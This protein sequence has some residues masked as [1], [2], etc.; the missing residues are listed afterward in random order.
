GEM[1]AT[2]TNASKGT[3][4]HEY[5]DLYNI[6][7]I[8]FPDKTNIQITYNQDKDWVTSFK[9]RA[10]C[11]E[12]YEYKDDEEDAVNNYSSNVI[13]VCNKKVTN[14]SSYSFWHKTRKD[15]ARYLARSLTNINGHEEDIYYHEVYGRPS[16]TIKDGRIQTFEYFADGQ[17]KTRTDDI[18][19]YSYKYD[20]SCHKVS[21]LVQKVK[22]FSVAENFDK[23][24]RNPS[25]TDNEKPKQQIKTFLTDFTYDKK[26]CNLI[27]AKNNQGQ[28]ANI[29]YDSVGRMTKILDQSK[30][31][32]TISYEERFGKPYIVNRPGL[33][34]IKFKYKS[35][36]SIE[37]YESDENSLVAIQ[38]ASIFNNLL[39]II[40]PATTETN[41]I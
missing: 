20:T 32:L 33:G 38:V 9:D 12:T 1:L 8:T 34:T 23:K 37:K 35:D 13:K 19:E 3:F 31:L 39:E 27:S 41:N 40:A 28:L 29:S 6:T 30:R 22:Y 25:K 17:M 18:N 36:G 26:S 10:G 2:V 15:G 24:G 4:K 16:E 7:N 11:K 5:D 14:R 21:Q